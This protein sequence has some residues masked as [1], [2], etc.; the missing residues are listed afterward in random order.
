MDN[1]LETIT[2]YG[3]CPTELFDITRGYRTRNYLSIMRMPHGTYPQP[4]ILLFIGCLLLYLVSFIHIYLS[5]IKFI[6]K[7]R[8]FQSILLLYRQLFFNTRFSSC[9]LSF[10]FNVTPLHV[11]TC[12]KYY[13]QLFIGKIYLSLFTC[14][15]IPI[16]FL[17]VRYNRLI[18]KYLSSQLIYWNTCLDNKPAI[19]VDFTLYFFTPG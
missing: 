6:C 19:G 10:D 15:N 1:D 2:D 9:T 3:S 13:T 11:F 5:Y 17:P 8:L 18:N 16:L 12:V 4:I 14:K 7:Y